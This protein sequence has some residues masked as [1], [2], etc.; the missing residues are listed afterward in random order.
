MG[1]RGQPSSIAIIPARGGSKRILHKNIRRMLDRPLIAWPISAALD[2][3][4]FDHVVVSTDDPEIA[5]IAQSSGAAVPFI[6]PPDLSD[7]EAGTAPVIAH[8]VRTLKDQGLEFDLVCCIYPAAL[9]PVGDDFVRSRDSLTR[10]DSAR[11][12]A[13][14]TRFLAPIQNALSMDP[15]GYVH[16]VFPDEVRGKTQ[17]YAP[18]W[19]DAGQFYWGSCDA[20]LSGVNIFSD[21]LGYELPS[22]RVTDIDTED[23]WK[24][25]EIVQ[26][27]ILAENDELPNRPEA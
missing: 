22:W 20:W 3:G 9:A 8:A 15:S 21:C 27:F 26:Q 24:R 6:R 19:H 14:V 1:S 7:D 25:A 16:R 13:S 18:R 5:S 17:D 12:V 23:D 11:F 2:S 4:I 10:S